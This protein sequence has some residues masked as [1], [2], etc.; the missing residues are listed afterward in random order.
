[1]RKFGLIGHPIEHSLSPLLFKAAYDDAVDM[2]YDLIQTPSFDD[3]VA[4][5]RSGYDAIN[6][7]APFKEMA[8]RAADD[9]D[10]YAAKLGAAN[11]LVKSNG[12]I[13]AYNTDCPGVMTILQEMPEQVGHSV[14][15]VGCGG[16]G[17][18]A[19][20][21][22]ASLGCKVT[23]A[24]RDYAKAEEFSRKMGISP[25]RLEDIPHNESKTII[26]TL[27][28]YIEFLGDLDF[29]GKTVLEANYRNPSLERLCDD[30]GGLYIHGKRWLMEQAI[31]GFKVMTGLEP[32]GHQIKGC[33]K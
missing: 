33:L 9:A 28:I 4:M 21:A 24:N 32:D 30:G 1:M 8:F 15:V 18:A 10:E 20:L 3:A 11:V 2:S 13:K 16:A 6:V 7:T 14:L 22:A 19:A 29:G 25:I 5:F 23:I 26:Y 31:Y 17:K 27:P 12:K